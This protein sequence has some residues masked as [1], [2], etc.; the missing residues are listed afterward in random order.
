MSNLFIKS[1]KIAINQCIIFCNSVN[2]VE[3]LSRKIS[4]LGFPCFYIHGQMGQEDRNRVF[5]NFRQGER[6]YLVCTD[7]FTRG[8]DI[9]TLNVVINFDFPLSANTYLHRIGRSGRFGHRGLAINFISDDV[10]CSLF[11]TFLK[12]KS[13]FGNLK[14]QMFL[15]RR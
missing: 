11:M 7:I 4:R 3:L 8:I 1:F 12:T 10:T 2:R 15:H 6:R 13:F 14:I 5:H 9:K